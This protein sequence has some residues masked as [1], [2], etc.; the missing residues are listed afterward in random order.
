MADGR[1]PKVSKSE[2]KRS[3]SPAG[4]NTSPKRV[5]VEKAEDEDKKFESNPYLSHWNEKNGNGYDGR[6]PAGSPLRDF[7]CRKT[8]AKQAFEAEDNENNPFTGQ[9][10]SEQYFNILK[11]RRNLP[12]HK[13]R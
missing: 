7:K 13:Q 12:V 1:N 9:P 10:H 2:R 6:L 5:K 8:T 11:T 3:R 4:T